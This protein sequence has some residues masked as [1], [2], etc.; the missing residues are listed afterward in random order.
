MVFILSKC[1]KQEVT[2]EGHECSNEPEVKGNELC[3][4]C[5]NPITTDYLNHISKYHGFNFEFI[6]KKNQKVEGSSLEES[7]IPKSPDNFLNEWVTS[8]PCEYCG[9][10]LEL[11]D[12]VNHVSLHKIEEVTPGGP[13]DVPLKPGDLPRVIYRGK[14][15]DKACRICLE[16]YEQGQILIYLTCIHRF[17]EECIM[18]W[19]ENK[20]SCPI[21]KKSPFVIRDKK[22]KGS[23]GR[24]AGVVVLKVLVIILIIAGE[25]LL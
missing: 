2:S 9:E 7:K 5:H 16:D 11:E 17:H 22:G 3:E 25:L 1:S 13:D 24:G 10:I 12:Y 18:H 6:A 21:C 4:I 23:I 19:F 8:S 15:L 14:G 20:D